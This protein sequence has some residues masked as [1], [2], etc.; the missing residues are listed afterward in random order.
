MTPHAAPARARAITTRRALIAVGAV[1][2]VLAM[3]WGLWFTALLLLGGEGSLPPKSRIPAV[4]AGAAVVDQSEACGSGGCWWRLTVTPPPGQSPEDLA[5]TMGLESEKTL[6][7]KLFDP[8]FVQVGAEP[9]E[10][11]LVIYVGYR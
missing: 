5:R 1:V 2:V 7:P 8:G 3:I 10:D 11:Q 4:P 9:R 6:G